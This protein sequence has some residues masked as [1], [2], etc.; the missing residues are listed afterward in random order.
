M[1]QAPSAAEALFRAAAA[2]QRAGRLAA[3][4]RGWRTLLAQAPGVQ[5]AHHNLVAALRAQG[6]WAEAQAALEAAARRWPQ[7]QELAY[8]L[9]IARLSAG[10]YAGGWPLY[11][12]RRHVAVDRVEAPALTT[13]EW[14]GEAVRSLLVWPEQGF[15]DQIQFARY[16]PL[17]QARGIAVTLICKPAMARLFE[18]FGLPIVVAEGE[19]TLPRHD[20]WTLMGSLPLRFGTTLETIPPGAFLPAPAGGRG[21]GVVTRGRPSH[22][23]DAHRSLPPAVAAALMALPGAVSLHPE[24]TGAADFAD[25]AEIIRGLAGVVTVDTSVAHLA[26]AMGKPVRILLPAVGVDWRWLRDRQDSP[27][28][29]SATLIRQARPG[30]W[31]AALA[32]ARA[33]F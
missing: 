33:G 21:V 11:E 9:A 20:A 32:A 1:A 29:P 13:P 4:E 2:H 30:D 18:V 10:D 25:T 3:A 22:P 16:L 17:L 26:G 28:H 24:D 12:A 5:P 31:T 7:D 27:W 8:H 23:N 14:R 19:A 6:K 15:G